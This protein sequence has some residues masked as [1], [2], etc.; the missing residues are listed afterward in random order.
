M[1]DERSPKRTGAED[2]QTK[3]PGS[4]GATSPLNATK[5]SPAKRIPVAVHPHVECKVV[6][7]DDSEGVE[8]LGEGQAPRDAEAAIASAASW[9]W[10]K[11]QS[12]FA[13]SPSRC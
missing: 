4:E 10:A 7:L 8:A 9:F 1:D 2:A 3:Q 5:T 12:V 13:L 6:A 11:K